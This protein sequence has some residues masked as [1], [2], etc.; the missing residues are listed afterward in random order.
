M[1]WIID[2][3]K[4]QGEE[5]FFKNDITAIENSEMIFMAVNTPTKQQELE[6]LQTLYTLRLVQRI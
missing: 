5:T 2:V 6:W 1:I 3:I 4:T